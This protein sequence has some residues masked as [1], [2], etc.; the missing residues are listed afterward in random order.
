MM[1]IGLQ[2]K[3]NERSSKR[4]EY[5][6]ICDNTQKRRSIEPMARWTTQSRFNHGIKVKI[7]STMFL[8]FQEG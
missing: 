5:K 1:W 6:D 4:I 8:H 3:S 7:H 2:N